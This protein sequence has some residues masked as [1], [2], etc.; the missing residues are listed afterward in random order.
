MAHSATSE[1]APSFNE[2]KLDEKVETIEQVPLNRS[3][4]Y[5]EASTE[6]EKK[7]DRSLNL[8]LDFFI[9]S[10]LAFNFLV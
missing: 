10:L 2:E 8:K 3:Q 6:D 4:K 7:L 1:K 9:V 5:Y